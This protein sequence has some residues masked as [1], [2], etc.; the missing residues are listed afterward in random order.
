MNRNPQLPPSEEWDFRQIDD[1]ALPHAT[2]YEY[3]RSTKGLRARIVSWLGTKIKRRTVRE[4]LLAAA[5]KKSDKHLIDRVPV[6]IRGQILHGTFCAEFP[7]ELMELIFESR[8]DFPAPWLRCPLK[9]ERNSQFSRILCRP[10]VSTIRHLKKVPNLADAFE[11]SDPKFGYHYHLTVDWEG[12]TTQ[13][14]IQHLEKWV[15]AEAKRHVSKRGAPSQA[16]T[17]KLKAL[18]ALRLR[19]ADFTYA[20]AQEALRRFSD[21]NRLVPTFANADGWTDAITRATRELA[22]LEKLGF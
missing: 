6:P 22:R 15:R 11:R 3:A 2:L 5:E 1:L 14:I 13:E 10:M 20:K 9:Y 12:A 8:P 17:W 16:Q 18:A 19:R 7:Y 21:G 4:H